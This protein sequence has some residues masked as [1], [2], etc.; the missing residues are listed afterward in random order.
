[1]DAAPSP[2]QPSWK[3]SIHRALLGAG[4]RSKEEA[5]LVVC[6]RCTALLLWLIFAGGLLLALALPHVLDY[7]QPLGHLIMYGDGGQ[8]DAA[9][10]S[11]L[12]VVW[13][14]FLWRAAESP[15]H[16]AGVILGAIFG[17]LGHAF[18]MTVVC[19]RGLSHYHYWFHL[20]T[21]I[22][23]VYS[24][25]AAVAVY[26]AR[27]ARSN[28]AEGGPLRVLFWR[29]VPGDLDL[30]TPAPGVSLRFALRS[31]CLATAGYFAVEFAVGVFQPD[32]FTFKHQPGRA[33]MFAD[34]EHPDAG[35]SA[36]V[37]LVLAFV[38]W[39]A[40][41]QERIDSLHVRMLAASVWAQAAVMTLLALQHGRLF[42]LGTD[43]PVALL[44]GAGLLFVAAQAKRQGLDAERRGSP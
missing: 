40:S 21:D 38:G 17:N 8:T 13:P 41:G 23:L 28:G 43:I 32:L 24:L 26:W 1:M 12:Y 2:A 11:V 36:A 15:S 42:R 6:L 30:R 22:P 35:M 20:L 27:Y 4:E 19:L 16:H 39:W 14:V 9:L 25:A 3:R 37:F 18:V 44:L 34:G 29:G 7:H 31:F 5:R 33:L 10:L